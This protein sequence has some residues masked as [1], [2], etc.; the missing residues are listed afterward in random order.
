MA[1]TSRFLAGVGIGV[2]V[3]IAYFNVWL[4]VLFWPDSFTSVSAI[5]GARL[6]WANVLSLLADFRLHS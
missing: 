6:L 3:S 2:F 5:F 4:K 1:L